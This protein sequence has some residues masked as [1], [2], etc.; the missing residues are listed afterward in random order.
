[1]RAALACIFFFSGCAALLFESLW[2]RQALLAFGSSVW[3]SSLVLSSFMAGI[4]LGN[5]AAVRFGTRVQR[6]V[7]A[8]GL[9]ELVVG[10][11]GI[12]LVVLLPMLGPLLGPVFRPV[13][14]TGA[15]LQPLRFALC[16]VVL[17]V[18]AVALGATLPLLVRALSRRPEDFGRT[19]GALYGW[20]TLGAV[21]GAVVGEVY[22][23][24]PLGVLGTAAVAGGLNLLAAVGAFALV[25]SNSEDVTLPIEADATRAS[26]GRAARRAARLLFAAFLSGGILLALE[27]VWFRLLLLFVEATTRGFAVMLAVVLAGIGVGSLAASAWMRRDPSADRHVWAVALAAGAIGIFG[28]GQLDIALRDEV[29]VLILSPTGLAVAATLMLPVSAASGVLFTLLGKALNDSILVPVRSAGLVTLVNTLGAAIGPLVAGF[30]LLPRLGVE[31]SV[32]LL[33][34]S[35]GAVAF[36][37]AEV[38]VVRAARLAALPALAFL[39]T[40]VTFPFGR[41]DDTYLSLAAKKLIVPGAEIVA[42]REGL[43]ETIQYSR[44]SFLGEPV[45]YQLLTNGY[46]MSG[47]SM[48]A[49]RYMGLFVYLPAAFHA[50]PRDALLISYG[51]GITAKSLIQ[52]EGIRSIDVV[53]ISRDILEMSDVVFPDPAEHPLRDPRVTIH[54]ED[55]R[56]FLQTTTK[57]FDLITAEPPPPRHGNVTYLYTQ[58]YFQLAHDRLRPGGLLSYWLPVHQLSLAEAASITGAFCAVFE[59]CSLWNGGTLNW[60]LLGSRGGIAPIDA[61]SLGRQWR[62]PAAAAE[63]RTIGVESPEALGALFIADA[64]QLRNLTDRAPPVRDAFPLRIHNWISPVQNVGSFLQYQDSG[65]S[66]SRFLQSEWIKRVWPE[67][68]RHET[69]RQFRTTGFLDRSFGH[70]AARD[71]SVRLRILHATLETSE[72]ETLPLLV[73][74]EDPLKV[75]I[76]E[77]RGDEVPA[78]AE[79]ELTLA[80]GALAR[81]A[82]SEAAAHYRAA[83]SLGAEFG[84]PRHLALYAHCRAGEDAQVAALRRELFD[85]ELDPELPRGLGREPGIDGCWA[86][87]WDPDWQRE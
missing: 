8:Y 85:G 64:K 28:Y 66:R 39:A 87:A 15:L 72:L 34:A 75:Q 10:A 30:V 54:V 48:M 6:P 17:L 82:W 47:T 50:E 62:N 20:N 31:L 22:L 45:L 84:R 52:V 7:L 35:Y 33:C 71:E 1:V 77:R 9:L 13:L 32:L 27:V 57:N 14:G 18:P 74:S 73:L 67:E 41:M 26:S 53:D 61:D 12:T 69:L 51:V 63:L 42:R 29:W 40:V 78:S 25:R 79:V 59:D 36:L 4:A 23:L 24:S 19:L 11:L 70:G 58:E 46:W 56:Y 76:A 44:L 83:V 60:T 65:D 86:A 55:G 38:A 16:F 68:L 2:F 21:F 81:R 5:A 49:R 43:T 37:S 80:N 3:A